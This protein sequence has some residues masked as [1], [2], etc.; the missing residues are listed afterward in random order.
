MHKFAATLLLLACPT[1]L[2]AQATEC[3]A[4]N[5]VPNTVLL[6]WPDVPTEDSIAAKLS[7]QVNLTLTNNGFVP[8]DYTLL[9]RIRAAG[10]RVSVPLATGVLPAGAAQ[11]VGLGLDGFGIDIASLAFSGGLSV[12][13]NATSS[14]QLVERSFSPKLFFHQEQDV[15][16]AIITWLYGRA[17]RR[18]VYHSGD[19]Q[20]QVFSGPV[21]SNVLGV[22][23]GGA[24]LG[25]DA[26]DHGPILGGGQLRG[27][28]P[29]PL[30]LDMWEFCMR[31]VYESID[32]GFGE[33]YYTSGTLMKARGMKV[34]VDHDNWAQPQVFFAN[35]INGCFSFTSQ[36]NSGFLIT[37]FAEAKLGAGDDIIVRTFDTAGLASAN[38]PDTVEKWMFTA[39]PGGQPRRVYYE[40]EGSD[41]SNLMAFG[42]FAFH[43]V[44]SHTSPG[45][46]GKLYL[47]LVT[48]N[49][50]CPG[51]GSCQIDDTVRMKPGD[52]NRKF[53]VAHE[54][55]HWI[56]R[57]WTNDKLGLLQGS[58]SANSTDLDCAYLAG[59]A[60]AMRS[61]EYS[62]GAFV[63][64]FAHFLAA[65]AWNNHNQQNGTFKY[66]KE[67]QDPAYAD[68]AANQYRV[69]LEG[70]GGNP[71]GGISNWM[72]NMCTVHDGHSVEMDWLRFYWDYRT[73]AGVSKPTHGDILEHVVYTQDNMPW[74]DVYGAYDQLQLA[75]EDP[76]LGQTQLENRWFQLANSNGVA[77]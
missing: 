71:I 74:V 20:Y 44:D 6:T 37:V 73:N 54:V 50:N 65:L 60:H 22:F 32:S 33:D 77:Q 56:H 30:G 51:T 21:P 9:G 12:E 5:L 45:L 34:Q 27:L 28:R 41:E 66:Y 70:I 52:S 15:T 63:D 53:L 42:S 48:S 25:Y 29:S 40:N 13:C 19:L 58:Y 11:S 43:W 8:V 31:W 46:Q 1:P 39:N 14:G 38:D 75:I 23:E 10:Q 72:A 3:G 18:D 76:Q 68:M 35:D 16:G 67:I 55:G 47:K 36:E 49:F 61:K 4:D 2:W 24:G 59:L 26:E 64:G 62:S 7:P 69:D 57:W 17:A